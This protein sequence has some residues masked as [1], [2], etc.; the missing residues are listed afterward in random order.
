MYDSAMPLVIRDDRTIVTLVLVA[1]LVIW[2]GSSRAWAR[3]WFVRQVDGT[4]SDAG[5]GSADRPFNSIN[6][7]AQL[8]QPGDVV[9]VGAGVYHEWVSPAR[10]GSE[11]VPIVYRAVPEHAA[12]IRGTDRLDGPWQPVAGSAG[13]FSAPLPGAAFLFGNPFAGAKE[14][15][16]NAM[17][18][19]GD[20]LLSQV[21]TREKLVEI[22]GSWLSSD[23][24]Q[25]LLIHP[26]N[27]GPIEVPPPA[28]TV[29][30]T[31]RDRIFAPHRRGLGYIQVEGFVLERCATRAGFPQLGAVS[32]RSGHHWI[33]RNNIVRQTTAR[34]IDCGSETYEPA[35]LIATEKEDQHILIAGHNLIEGNLL[36]DNAEGGIA[37]WNTDFVRIIGNV[38]RNNC[39]SALGEKEHSLKDFEAGGIK[40]HCF[41]NGVIERN[42]VV[43]NSSFGI[44][45]DDGWENARVTRNVCIGNHGAGIFVEFG[46]GPV[47]VDHNLCAGNVPLDP[48]Y[49]GDGI[50]AHDASGVTIEHNTLLDNPHYGL[51]MRVVADRVYWPKR[52]AE[53]SNE[54]IRGNLFHGNGDG[55]ISLPFDSPRSHD[56]HSDRN[57]VEPAAVFVINSNSGRIA[58]QT[59]LAACR[60]RLHGTDLP[61]E[62]K[63]P[64]ADPKRV[65][66]LPLS[67][68]RT[69]MQ[70]DESTALL[71]EEFRMQLDKGADSLE[72]DLPAAD[73]I[74]AT[75][76]GSADDFD[77]LGQ[78]IEKG[79]AHAGA[80]EHLRM[81]HQVIPLWSLPARAGTRPASPP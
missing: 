40:V 23:D 76:A 69:V 8:A 74:P 59:I 47:V 37:A 24:G 67:G 68:W 63:R 28:G 27:D 54:T 3:E 70:M 49:F 71:P 31:T 25:Q 21:T 14:Q 42:L 81:G 12:I 41:R 64:D 80:I 11:G 78:A 9:T 65:V 20:Q 43:N 7:A 45:L 77:L 4:T 30:I 50:Y 18:F 44:W 35:S 57:A 55:A 29:E 15:K 17:V 16:R 53:T 75:P 73:A 33:I 19:F 38:V 56:N 34:G 36:S 26:P 46:F 79:Q 39:T 32:T 66:T 2:H 13:V 52:I 6:A 48:P 60:E 58:P 10:A 72:I 62:S 61:A 22:K 51:E 5:D 1:L